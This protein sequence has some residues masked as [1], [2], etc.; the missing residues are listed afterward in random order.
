[1]ALYEESFLSFKIIIFYFLF[2]YAMLS[3]SALLQINKY[4]L[5]LIT[6]VPVSTGFSRIK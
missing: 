1:M 2:F 6:T 4:F 5:I 3:G